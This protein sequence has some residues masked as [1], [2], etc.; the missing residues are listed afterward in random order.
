MRASQ[1]VSGVVGAVLLAVSV[2]GLT[3]ARGG[4]EMRTDTVGSIPVRLYSAGPQSPTVVVAHGFA[5][6]AQL[7]EPLALGL[8]EAGFTVVALDF[9]G[10]GANGEVLPFDGDVRTATWDA[11]TAPL[12]E[13]LD[14]AALQPEVDRSRVA[15]L[16][17]SMGAGAAVAFAVEDALGDGR[18]LATAALSLPSADDIPEG[19]TS[20]PHDLLLLYGALEPTAFADAALAGLRAAYPEGFAG[21]TYGDV[22]EGSA[23]RAEAIPFVEHISILLS[24]ATLDATVSW[25][26]DALDVEAQ[27][28]S[29]P[30]L[31]LYAVLA[32]LA[33]ALLL[34]PVSTLALGAREHRSWEP[35]P[36]PVRGIRVL[37][38]VLVASV[39]GVL[40]A[41]AAGP[42]ADQVPVAVGGYLAA[43]FAVSG[44]VVLLWWL[45]RIRAPREAPTVTGR[46]VLGAVIVTA[47]AV[48][49]VVVPGA[50][51]W[52]A[53]SF[54]GG[55]LWVALLLLAVFAL[56]FGADEL[57][58][59]RSSTG[60]RVA[61][62]IT[63]RVIAVAALLGA[64]PL[65]GAPG[66][67]L[68]VAPVLLALLV[69]LGAYA[70]I[71]A[72]RQDPYLAA[73]LVQ[74]VPAAVL[75]STTFPLVG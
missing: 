19:E 17:H 53:F 64:I 14:W 73:V 9:P 70:A 47:L 20:V 69:L 58:L 37:A 54:A 3:T 38:I 48:L 11:L 27:P 57:I 16:G 10:H 7:M 39:V 52:S 8:H 28:S 35:E 44:V 34:V 5:G 22:G 40:A 6:S 31:P 18:V 29:V 33:G 50:M 71:A 4:G 36:D 75:V 61:L 2:V 74:A 67:L 43:W 68:I 45:L 55:R 56:W 24:P 51:S 21:V 63:S 30:P 62:M 59:R 60:R 72:R 23:R 26:A 15:L 41:W 49:V 42:L 13:V 25:L 65:L 1:I 66:F 32:L 46:S 12:A